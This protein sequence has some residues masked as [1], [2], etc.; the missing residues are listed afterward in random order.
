[1]GCSC[2]ETMSLIRN[3]G[4]NRQDKDIGEDTER[5]DLVQKRA[6]K[7]ELDPFT[8]FD[9]YIG[10]IIEND[11]N[12][13]YINKEFYIL[14]K[15]FE[16]RKINSEKLKT[17]IDDEYNKLNKDN[18]TNLFTDIF[19]N[20]MKI[21]N[22]TDIKNIE[23]I[24]V[25]LMEKFQNDNKTLKEFIYKEVEKIFDYTTLD[26]NVISKM[27]DQIAN[28]L[29]EIKDNIIKYENDNNLERKNY[30]I[31][32]EDFNKFILQEKL[33]LDS[34]ETEYL[35]YK[36]KSNLK[37]TNSLHELNFKVLLNFLDNKYD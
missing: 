24:F 31:S 18:S 17:L 16:A 5:K 9:E 3:P 36:M 2:T 22:E 27:N 34:E 19:K 29:N 14:R 21:N 35:L 11:E 4:K 20:I 7:E 15:F 28:K 12:V 8:D 1:M 10:E 6:Y 23:N 33:N 30:I 13:S 32:F 25:K 26:K 37:E